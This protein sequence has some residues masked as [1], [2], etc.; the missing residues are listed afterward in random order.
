MACSVL[1]VEDDV[2]FY[3]HMVEM[4]SHYGSFDFARAG[5]KHAAH[6]AIAKR[7]FDRWIIDVCLAQYGDV[8]GFEFLEEARAKQ[9]TTRALVFSG[10]LTL[11]FQER[12]R[13]LGAVAF[14][15]KGAMGR[16][17]TLARIIERG[18]QPRLARCSAPSNEHDRVAAEIEQLSGKAIPNLE[19]VEKRILVRARDSEPSLSAA[20]RRI[21]MLRQSYV[22]KL[23]K[24][25]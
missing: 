1:W 20:A 6:V 5:S 8:S 17:Q 3:T 4:L 14:V 16:P 10:E 21:G 22:K 9:N 2:V 24:L 12:A 23:K 15:K 7:T 11:E 18:E 25:T 13:G 19:E